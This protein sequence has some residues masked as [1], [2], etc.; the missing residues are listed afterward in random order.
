[1]EKSEERSRALSRQETILARID[2]AAEQW[3]VLTLCRALL[4]ETRKIYET[5]RQPEVLRQA[6]SFFT[7]MTEGCYIR[8]IAPMDGGE[9][10]VER[11]DGVRLSPQLLSRGTAEQLY[12]SMRLALVR[13]YANHVDPLPVVFDDIF[14]NFDS[15]RSRTTFKAIRELSSTHQV[16]LFTCHLH[17]MK[18]VEEIVPAA[19]LFP[20]Q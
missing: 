16:L 15:R 3:A 20:L 4:D 13:E 8:I 11:R 10:Q 1:M 12:L 6:S 17:L 18:Q 7:V 14:V 9:I 5:E 2:E 19:K